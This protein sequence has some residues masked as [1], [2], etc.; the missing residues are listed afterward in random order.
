MVVPYVAGG[1]VD[2]IGRLLAN[3]LSVTGGQQV[4]PENRGG[5][6]GN[7][8]AQAVI[9]SPADGYSLLLG[10]V[11][12]ATNPYI[13]PSL[14]YDPVADL[15][16]VSMICVF[17]NLMAVS[18]SSPAK[19]VKEF[20]AYAKANPGKISFASAGVGTSQHLSGEMF[21]MMASVDMVHVPYRGGAAVIN[22]LIPGR[23]DTFFGNLASLLP[24]VQS[25]TLRGLAVT[26]A[27]R[28]PMAPQI[29]TIAESAV[30]G[31]DVSS[32]YA[33]FMHAKTPAEILTKV[34][35]DV[36]TALANPQLKQKIEEAATVTPSTPAEL[37]THLKSE[38]AKWGP[39]IKAASIKPE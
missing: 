29:P 7:I 34:H 6:G 3:Q 19:S 26:S 28:S 17:P 20:I 33:L 2:M 1:G 22:D 35:G 25:G 21:K 5:A 27:T 13:Y 14:G 16:P 39:I 38:L 36:V 37:A 12:L 23:V 32:W 31:Y 30:P 11:F 10:S 9:A 8:G 24:Q 18:N 4:V 15:A